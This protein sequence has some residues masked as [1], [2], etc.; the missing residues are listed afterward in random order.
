MREIIER[1][2]QKA[3]QL[4]KENLD[5]LHLLANTLLERETIDGDQMDRVLRGEK[6]GPP[7]RLSD[8]DA[9]PSASAPVT[10]ADEEA[11]RASASRARARPERNSDRFHPRKRPG[12]FAPR[13][14]SFGTGS[15]MS[16]VRGVGFREMSIRESG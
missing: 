1:A 13:A 10:Q 7:P 6:L 5:K 2:H 4:L 8:L 15:P 3:L 11:S 16:S 9:P 12:R 14:F